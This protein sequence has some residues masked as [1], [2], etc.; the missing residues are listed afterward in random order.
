[1][2]AWWAFTR[3]QVQSQHRASVTNVACAGLSSNRGA[4]WSHSN[5]PITHLGND[6]S[7]LRLPR[8][9]GLS[10]HGRLMARLYVTLSDLANNPSPL[11]FP[12]LCLDT[13]SL[14]CLLQ[15]LC[16]WPLDTL[17]TENICVG[18]SKLWKDALAIQIYA[19]A[20]PSTRQD[21]DVQR[22]CRHWKK[23][24]HWKS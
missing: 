23:I 12:P 4:L 6:Q 24:I 22:I 21:L 8:P 13:P 14:E 3:L 16:C 2:K 18:A 1:M 5:M 17:W 9:R 10:K 19:Q 20:E 15:P 7:A 11:P